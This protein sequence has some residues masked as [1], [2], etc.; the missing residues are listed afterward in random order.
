MKLNIALSIPAYLVR[1]TAE[2]F[3]Y[4]L[5]GLLGHILPVLF[6]DAQ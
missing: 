1:L 3:K 4:L 2:S 5:E 6:A